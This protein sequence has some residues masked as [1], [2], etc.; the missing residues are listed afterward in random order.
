MAHRTGL[1][2]RVQADLPAALAHVRWIGGGS[3]AGKST[4][5]RRLAQ[6]HGAVV[7]SCDAAMSEHAKRCPP[8]QCPKLDA[9]KAATMDERWVN[10]P[11]ERMLATFHWF[12]GECFDYIADDLS[13]LPPDQPV[14]AEGFRLLPDLVAPL[15]AR[16]ANA[17]W[18]LPT[19]AF[20]S[21]A[22]E[23]R[24]DTWAI[25]AQTS[26]PTRAH[27]NLM[28]RDA[29][30]TDRLRAECAARGLQTLSGTPAMSEDQLFGAVDRHLFA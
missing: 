10:D 24:G 17:L 30:F 3:G 29:L 15:L 20:R 18:L 27:A 13:E 6:A 22:L 25:A 7:Y 23:A 26:N 8:G 14:I 16:P 9:F 12:A 5:A 21:M 4:I 2:K 28:A 11:P 19:P 1:T